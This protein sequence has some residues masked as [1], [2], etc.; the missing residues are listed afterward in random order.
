MR[1]IRGILI[2]PIARL[3]HAVPIDGN[4]FKDISKKLG[5][6]LFTVVNLTADRTQSLYIDDEGRLTYP[7]PL[8]YFGL[9][10]DDGEPMGDLFCGRGLVLGFDPKTGESVSTTMSAE[11][12]HS[13]T[14]FPETTPSQISITPLMTVTDWP[15]DSEQTT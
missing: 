3:V 12:L 11:W 7:N 5:C 9:I 10:G 2:D 6:S 4:D 1:I 8:G 15:D 14:Y 13:R